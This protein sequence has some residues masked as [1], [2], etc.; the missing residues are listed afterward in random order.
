MSSLSPLKPWTTQSHP[1][2]LVSTSFKL[3]LCWCWY[4]GIFPWVVFFFL[5][6]PICGIF[7]PRPAIEPEPWQ[8]KCWVL[9]TGGGGLVAKLCPTLTSP[10]TVACQTPLCM[11]FSKQEYWGGLPFP[12]PGDLPDPGIKPGSPALQ[13]D[14]LPTELCGKPLTTRP[15]GMFSWIV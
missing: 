3:L 6:M 1:W 12:S 2:G 14:S 7:V 15:P 4:F 8:W 11:G 5:A 9:S 10:W 13:T